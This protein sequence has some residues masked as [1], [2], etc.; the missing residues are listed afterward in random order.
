MIA[1]TRYEALQ[2]VARTFATQEAMAEAFGVTQPTV[3]RWLTQS[4]QI[5]GEHVL[6]AEELTGVSRHDLRPDLYPRRDCACESCREVLVD[7]A[8]ALRFV[9][10]DRRARSRAD[11]YA[12]GERLAQAG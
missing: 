5:P 12:I 2:A 9:G 6:P 11:R 10:I 1:L 8:A 3:C 4:K 7:Q